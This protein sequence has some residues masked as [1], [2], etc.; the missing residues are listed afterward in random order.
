[1]WVSLSLILVLLCFQTL[2]VTASIS[3]DGTAN[4]LLIV[5]DDTGIDSFSGYHDA[6][7]YAH[8]ASTPNIDNLADQGVRFHNAWSHPM[9]S[10]ARASIYTGRHAFRHGITHPSLIPLDS[11]ELTIAELIPDTYV[12][13]YFGKWHLGS[14]SGSLPT[15]QGFDYFS[16][17]LENIPDYFEWTKTQVITA[18]SESTTETNTTYATLVN[19]DEALKW[20]DAQHQLN[21]VWFAIVAY[22]AGHS[23]FHVPPKNLFS[24]MSLTGSSGTVCTAQGSDA[25]SDCFRAM[26]EALDTSIGTL[27]EGLPNSDTLVIVV[28][29]NG[30]P[31]NVIVA[32]TGFPY[33]ADHGKKTVYEGGVNVPFIMQWTGDGGVSGLEVTSKMVYALDIFATVLEVA[34]VTIPSD[35]EIDAQ[36]LLDFVDSTQAAPIVRTE[37]FTELS[38]GG[39]IDR[40]ALKKR[41]PTGVEYKYIYNEGTNECYN[42]SNDAS[43]LTNIWTGNRKGTTSIC[44]RLKDLTPNSI[45]SITEEAIN[46]TDPLISLTSEGINIKV[47]FSVLITVAVGISWI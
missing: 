37:L 11:S 7:G 47:G 27:L 16:G 4:I 26:V 20:I 24:Q 46:T 1:M 8:S 21:N 39:D 6:N 32:Q 40:W 31:G 18:G 42:I 45:T 30:T 41:I 29:D 10:P 3:T 17:S 44:S 43:E 19:T 36:S 9:C 14:T 34:G 33:A 2:Y 12:S 38:N 35:L 28:G 23:P 13:G 5:T 15:D 22:N 25:P